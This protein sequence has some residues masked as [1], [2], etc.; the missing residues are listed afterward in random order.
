MADSSN[1]QEERVVM[2]MTNIYKPGTKVYAVVLNQ[3]YRPYI[4]IDHIRL[5]TL[6]GRSV[7]YNLEISGRD[8]SVL[9]VFDTE[10]KAQEYI[11]RHYK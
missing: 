5:V 9:F 6:G 3:D 7:D 8:I 11:I 2:D 10:E 4:I 1:H